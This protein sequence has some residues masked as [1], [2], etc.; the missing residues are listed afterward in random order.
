[1]LALA[2]VRDGAQKPGADS[3]LVSARRV[4]VVGGVVVV[5]DGATATETVSLAFAGRT[6][7]LSFLS[8]RTGRRSLGCFL[9]LSCLVSQG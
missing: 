8:L 9:C 6:C 1:V 5:V 4:G 3:R 7:S 2:F